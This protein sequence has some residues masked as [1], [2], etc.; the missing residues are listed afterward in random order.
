MQGSRACALAIGVALISACCGSRSPVPE[1]TAPSFDHDIAPVLAERCATAPG[2]HGADPTPAVDLDLRP[3]AA[4]REL[5]GV[6]AESGP[7]PILLVMPGDPDRSLLLLKVTG[8][9][10]PGQG[11]RMPMDPRTHEPA[12]VLSDHWIGNILVRWIEAGAP[13]D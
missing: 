7:V 9:L 13:R 6:P 10:G 2:C 4:Y 8:A 3:A 5:V 1:R 11:K 12:D